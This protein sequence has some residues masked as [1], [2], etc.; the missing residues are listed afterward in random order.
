LCPRRVAD[1]LRDRSRAI[2]RPFQASG[3]QAFWPFFTNWQGRSRSR[4]FQTTHCL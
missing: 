4:D 3:V 1:G 2:G